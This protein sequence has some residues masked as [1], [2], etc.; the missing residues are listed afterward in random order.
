MNEAHVPFSPRVFQ[1][2]G[3]YRLVAA[4]VLCGLA[5]V[6]VVRFRALP[7]PRLATLALALLPLPLL[8]LDAATGFGSL[9]LDRK[10]VV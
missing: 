3:R 9:D 4:P 10:S 6:A 8:T 5:G 7:W 1:Y 2:S